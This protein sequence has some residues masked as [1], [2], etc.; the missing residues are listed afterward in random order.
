[1]KKTLDIYIIVFSGLLLSTCTTP[2]KNAGDSQRVEAAAVVKKISYKHI[3]FAPVAE[4]LLVRGIDTIFLRQLL[5]DDR[6]AFKENLTRYNV[7]GYRNPPDYSHNYNEKSVKKAKE[8]LNNNNDALL[9]AENAYGVPKEV[10]ASILWIETKFGAILGKNNVPSVFLSVA[11]ANQPEYLAMNKDNLRKNWTG[12]SDELQE[13]DLKIER[14]SQKKSAWALDEL[15]ALDTLRRRSPFHP[16]ELYGSAAGAFGLSQFLP[17]S[18]LRWAKDGNGD[19]VINLFELRDA[20]HSI[21]NYL[22]TNGWGATREQKEKAV[23]HYNNSK[24]YVAAVLTL[25]DKIKR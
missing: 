25:A 24:D 23:F 22:K 21:G 19:N 8:F 11:M 9:S 13:L 16:L 10:I 6:V 3:I 20:M 14:R 1:M 4:S 18:Y 15:M 7:T 2:T 17:S 12:T 5:G